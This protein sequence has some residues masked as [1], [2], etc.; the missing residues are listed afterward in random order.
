MM[1]DMLE[2]Y[3]W[4]LNCL[5]CYH[6]KLFID[7]CQYFKSSKWILSLPLKCYCIKCY[8]PMC[9]SPLR[10]LNWQRNPLL[11]LPLK[12]KRMDQMSLPQYLFKIIIIYLINIWLDCRL[13]LKCLLP[14]KWWIS[15]E[16]SCLLPLYFEKS[17]SYMDNLPDVSYLKNV[18]SPS[19]WLSL[20]S[21]VWSFLCYVIYLIFNIY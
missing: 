13:P 16:R 5:R 11:S 1:N 14:Q 17:R 21:K 18:N 9:L 7:H 12:A 10:D 4:Y 6:L 20:T 2:Q 3:R 19:Q 15:E 8:S